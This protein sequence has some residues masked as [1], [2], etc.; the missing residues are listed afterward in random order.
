MALIAAMTAPA[1]AAEKPEMNPL[2]AANTTFALQLYGKLRST[3]GN[4]ALSPYSIS[5]AL[6]LTYAG[7]RGDTARQIEQTLHFDQSNTGVHE[8]FGRLDAAL[9]VAQGKNE[10]SIAN[11]VWPQAKYPFHEEFLN[12]L[13]K[14]YGATVTPLDYA[15]GAEGARA[16]INHWVDDKTRH[17]IA[18][19]IG[20]GVLDAMTRMVLVNAIYFKGTWATP[21]PASSTKPDKFYA[22]PDSTLTVPFMHQHGQFSYAENDQLQMLALPYLGQ[23]LQML[24]LLPRRRDGIGLLES[25][26]T[27]ASLTA[28][29]SGMR[30]Q[31]VNVALPKFKMS[32]GFMLAPALEALG[33]KDAFDP[34]R[35]DFSGMDGRAHWL[36]LSA[37]LHKAYIEVSEKGTEAAAATAVFALT[38]RRVELPREF[39]ADHPFLFLIRDETTG[40]ILFTGRVVKPGA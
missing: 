38:E 10:L 22:R 1:L 18:E 12:L 32:S 3:E 8:L 33:L 40:S 6:A 23:Q 2:V 35:A 37:V 29:T 19:I 9:K 30:N 25:S 17:K 14:D 36:Y 24:V 28:W 31:P 39:R 13:K 5:S 20:P 21:F 34:K 15:R 27:P 4:L 11:S 26:L 16:T 7:A